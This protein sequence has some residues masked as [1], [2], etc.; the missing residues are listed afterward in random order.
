MG[1]KPEKACERPGPIPQQ[2]LGFRVK[3]SPVVSP[4]HKRDFL[5]LGV[6]F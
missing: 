1:V 4:P 5:K 2:G 6:P 3:K